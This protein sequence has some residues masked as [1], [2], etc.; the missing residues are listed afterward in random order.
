MPDRDSRPCIPPPPRRFS[1]WWQAESVPRP[2]PTPCMARAR[3]ASVRFLA[4]ADAVVEQ[5]AAKL[6][7][8]EAVAQAKTMPARGAR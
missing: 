8:R 3:I 6:R 1:R 2:A 4:L 7:E 5:Q